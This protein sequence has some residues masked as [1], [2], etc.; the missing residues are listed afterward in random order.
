[1]ATATSHRANAPL[2]IW[3]RVAT[4]ALQMC[5]D[6]GGLDQ[7]AQ[8]AAEAARRVLTPH[9]EGAPDRPLALSPDCAA[10][11]HTACVGDAFDWEREQV[12]GCGCDCH[13]PPA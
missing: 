11:K 9:A 6:A 13:A 2:I 3:A 7:E 5:L 10:G 4:A 1:M 8:Q 12:I